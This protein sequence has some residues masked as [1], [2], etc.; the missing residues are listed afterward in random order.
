MATMALAS[1][2][3]MDAYVAAAKAKEAEETWVGVDLDATL[4]RWTG[5]DPNIGPPVP[6]MVKEV[7]RLRADGMRVKI[8]TARAWK[9]QPPEQRA[10]QIASV[11][12]WCLEH[13]GE[14]LPVTAEKDFYM[15]YLIDDRAKQ[16]IPNCGVFVED[17]LREALSLVG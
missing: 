11:E 4:A 15:A 6:Q 16:V 17:L 9:G 1:P 10:A 12:A 5:W 14:V 3:Q 8:M 13:L 7:K 2:E